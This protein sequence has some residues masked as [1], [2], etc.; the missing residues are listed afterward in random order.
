MDDTL[1][2]LDYTG[3]D[4]ATE[5]ASDLAAGAPLKLYYS[6]H[7]ARRPTFRIPGLLYGLNGPPSTPG[8]DVAFVWL[9]EAD[10]REGGRPSQELLRLGAAAF[11]FAKTYNQ[12]VFRAKSEEIHR[13]Y[14]QAALRD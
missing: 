5:T 11:L 13:L 10:F 4:G 8:L 9:R 3:R 7:D 6:A 14:P 2:L 1:G 12:R